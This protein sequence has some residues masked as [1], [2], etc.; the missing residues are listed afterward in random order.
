MDMLAFGLCM[1]AIIAVLVLIIVYSFYRDVEKKFAELKAKYLAE[2]GADPICGQYQLRSFDGGLNWCAVDPSSGADSPV[3]ILGPVEQVYP[4]LRQR[5]S[6][7]KD[8][9]RYMQQYGFNGVKNAGDVK[10]IMWLIDASGYSVKEDKPET[11]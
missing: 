9:Q 3:K 5:L 2:S 4:G 10:H 8:L 7:R 1:F 11:T 6:A